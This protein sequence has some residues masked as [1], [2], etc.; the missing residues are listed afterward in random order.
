MKVETR[1]PETTTRRRGLVRALWHPW[2]FQALLVAVLLA[3]AVFQIDLHEVRVTLDSV[4]YDWLLA[5]LAV[6]ILARWIPAIDWQLTLTKVGYV[7]V[8][9]L[10]GVLLIGTLVSTV[11]PASAGDVAKV[12]ILANRYGLPRAGTIAG[13]GAEAIVNGVL[14]VAFIVAAIAVPA[15]SVVPPIVIWLLAGASV[16]LFLAAAAASRVLPEELSPAAP[17]AWLPRR[18]EAFLREHWPRVHAGFEILRQT[19]LL[20]VSLALNLIGWAEDVAILW[21]FGQAFGLDIPLIG[22]IAAAVAVAIVTTF[23]ITVGNIGTYEVFIVAAL[24][25][26]GVSAAQALAF[27]VGTHIFSTLFNL[28]LGALA[29][30]AMRVHPGE[31]FRLARREGAPPP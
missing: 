22:Y 12:Q 3:V 20:V 7:P 10:F 23:P 14:M 8:S 15:A 9:S 17:L 29:V 4:R 24:K 18:A 26:Y 31:L 19:R 25:L 21:L 11:V 1:P 30:W 6:Y 2:L 13:R 28:A 27:A 16:V 5:A